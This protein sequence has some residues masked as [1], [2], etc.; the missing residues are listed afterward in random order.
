MTGDDIFLV[1]GVFTLGI[2]H[3]LRCQGRKKCLPDLILWLAVSLLHS[4][5][6]LQSLCGFVLCSKPLAR[7]R[8]LCIEVWRG[9]KQ[10]NRGR[11]K[12]LHRK[13]PI[14]RNLYLI[15][16]SLFLFASLVVECYLGRHLFPSPSI[17]TRPVCMY[18][19]IGVPIALLHH[20]S[21]K[22]REGGVV[23][24]YSIISYQLS[25]AIQVNSKAL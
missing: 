4:L 10:I 1:L 21:I 2:L 14:R 13:L 23:L 8:L 12:S 20:V 24:M 16:T 15:N 22:G 25:I 9:L 7:F 6:I 17:T 5:Y 18:T 11:K 3:I 19:Y